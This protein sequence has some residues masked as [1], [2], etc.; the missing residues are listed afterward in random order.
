M[1][2]TKFDF[3]RFGGRF[4]LELG[5]KLFADDIDKM[6]DMALQSMLAL[7]AALFWDHEKNEPIT[8]VPR[9]WSGFDSE[10]HCAVSPTGD[11]T[12]EIATGFGF[13]WAPAAI[14]G[15]FV[16]GKYLPVVVR[17]VTEYTLGG[18]SSQ[19]RVDLVSIVPA[20]L[21]DEEESR[22]SKDPSDPVVAP[23]AVDT[24][25]RRAF[26]S[27]IVITAG[28]PGVNPAAPNVPNGHL[29]L[30]YGEIPALNGPVT[31]TDIRPALQLG[32]LLNHAATGSG[33]VVGGGSVTRVSGTMQ[34]LVAAC[35][36][37]VVGIIYHFPRRFL[38]LPTGGGT[39]TIYVDKDG[40]DSISG[41]LA[42]SPS[43]VLAR[44]VVGASDTEIGVDSI[45]D[46]REF[47]S[48]G[49]SNIKSRTLKPDRMEF[50]PIEIGLSG[51]VSAQ[52]STFAR[53]NYLALEIDL[54]QIGGD[55]LPDNFGEVDL[56]I[57]VGYRTNQAFVE[58]DWG[59][60][61]GNVRQYRYETV[62][63]AA[64]L[65]AG[66]EMPLAIRP[67]SNIESTIDSDS[68]MF[69]PRG[70]FRVLDANTPAVVQIR[71]H[72]DNVLSTSFPAFVIVRPFSRVGISQ[73]LVFDLSVLGAASQPSAPVGQNV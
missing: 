20:Y 4:N 16:P 15:S 32:S 70:I 9:F 12:F 23:F 47:G 3:D 25:T 30:A 64:L 49:N 19:P 14:S 45:T 42:P 55:D 22:L 7:A 69:Q 46:L 43:V 28:T 52:P 11:L 56:E 53:S 61:S 50:C 54:K 41:V 39:Y 68:E 21:L 33:Y 65:T 59:V 73:V 1:A 40:A 66:S 48:I 37:D 44:V 31:W 71:L 67:T 34:V 6:G 24:A 57:E 29:P 2:N 58:A 10:P 38:T 51:E 17:E 63:S 72:T 13:V 5:A 35:R 27:S 60:P 8:G 18:H 62:S 36:V 26:G